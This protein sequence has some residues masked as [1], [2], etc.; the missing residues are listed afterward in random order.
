MDYR[1][2]SE[3]VDTLS[4]DKMIGLW[5]ALNTDVRCSAAEMWREDL[6]NRRY[7]IGRLSKEEKRCMS[8]IIERRVGIIRIANFKEAC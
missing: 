1:A 5:Y 2:I 6:L 3:F 8:M 7:W 4:G